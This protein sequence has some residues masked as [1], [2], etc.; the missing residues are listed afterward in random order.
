M[1][2]ASAGPDAEPGQDRSASRTRRTQAERRAA[3]RDRLL[4]A[5]IDCLVEAG[6][7]GLTTAEVETRA[8]VSRGAR[9]HYFPTKAELLAAAVDRLFESLGERVGDDLS[10]AEAAAMSE[11]DRRRAVVRSLWSKFLDPRVG[12][13]VELIT[14]ARC[15]EPLREQLDSV[16]GRWLGQCQQRALSYFPEHRGLRDRAHASVFDTIFVALSGLLWQR[17]VFGPGPSE[18]RILDTLEQALFG[19]LDAV[20]GSA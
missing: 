1:N 9:M 4:G 11:P 17:I 2:A 3:M 14:R 10:R 7:V 8:G 12:A 19:H 15:D 13:V 5:A 20:R 16:L 18:E 6:Y